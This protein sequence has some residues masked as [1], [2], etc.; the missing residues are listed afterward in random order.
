MRE[1]TGYPGNLSRAGRSLKD[2]ITGHYTV[3][4]LFK[5]VRQRTLTEEEG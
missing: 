5:W 2:V 3:D 1:L 4:L